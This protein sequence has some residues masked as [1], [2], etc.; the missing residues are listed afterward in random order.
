M[1][2]E[3]KFLNMKQA[4]AHIGQ[5]YRWMQRNYLNLLKAGVKAYRLPKNASKGRLIFDRDSLNEYIR[6]CQV[7][8]PESIG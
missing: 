6:S 8:L 3:A 4:G 1:F 5:S 7:E 2:L